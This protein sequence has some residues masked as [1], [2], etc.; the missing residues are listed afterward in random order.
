LP[1]SPQAQTPLVFIHGAQQDGFCWATLA[2]R[3]SGPTRPVLTPDLPGHGRN[4]DEALASVERLADWLLAWLDE[5]RID[6][7]TLIGHSLGSL[8]ALE[9]AAR[10]PHRVRKLALLGTAAPMRVAARLLETAAV[11]PAK[12]MAAVNRGSHSARGWLAAPSPVGLWSPGMNLRLME[13]QRPE[14]LALGLS[15][16]NNYAGAL[17]A[18]GRVRCPTLIV[19]GSEDRMTPP[20][21]AQALIDRLADVRV[22]NLR[23]AGHALMAEAPEA[24]AQALEKFLA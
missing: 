13:R 23:G 19:I 7:A 20:A 16:C 24:L 17:E 15:A 6:S 21:A 18:A 10:Q 3:L 9:A 11:N 4:R 1:I 22:V 8:I 5:Q 12:A 14:L 2:R